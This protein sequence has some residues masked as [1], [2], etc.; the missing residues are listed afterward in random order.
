MQVEYKFRTIATKSQYATGQT[1]HLL[2][3]G[4][5]HP[6]LRQ[7]THSSPEFQSENLH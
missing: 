2:T 4:I 3:P 1:T 6:P 7:T 5:H